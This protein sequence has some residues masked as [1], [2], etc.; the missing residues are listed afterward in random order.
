MRHLDTNIVIAHLKGNRDVAM[1]L[2]SHL[3]D[4]AISSLV[5]LANDAVLVT[6]NTRHFENIDELSLEDWLM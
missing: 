4:V 6:H 3:P 2:K 5:A 1:Q